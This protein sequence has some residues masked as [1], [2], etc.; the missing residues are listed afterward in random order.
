MAGDF[1]D[2]LDFRV[3]AIFYRA[4]NPW[5]V[6]AGTLAEAR[7]TERMVGAVRVFLTEV[8]RQ[9]LA[10]TD[11]KVRTG[12]LRSAVASG[13]KVWGVGTVNS[14]QAHWFVPDWV[15]VHETGAVIYP[16]NA[17]VLCVPLP[18]ALRPDGT[19]K[20]RSPREWKRFGTFSYTS[21][22]TGKS[23]L[24]YKDGDRLVVLYVYVDQVTLRERL[25]LRKHYRD[26]LPILMTMW[27]GILAQEIA[28]TAGQRFALAGVAVE[29]RL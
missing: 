2:I 18:D 1:V 12:R 4:L 10:D 15:A 28:A 24:A 7:V 14:I 29:R 11:L 5:R 20:R 13:F 25:G 9:T 6:A 21:K 3:P 19:P 27:E 16:R 26:M 8:A 17:R 23:Y 22:K